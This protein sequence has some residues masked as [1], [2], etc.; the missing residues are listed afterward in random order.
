MDRA[1]G[2][3]LSEIAGAQ[4]GRRNF[5]QPG[6]DIRHVGECFFAGIGQPEMLDRAA[7]IPERGGDGMQAV[8]TLA[9]FTA[10]LAG[11]TALA[12]RGG[13]LGGV[14]RFRAAAVFV[15]VH[16]A[17]Y[18]WLAVRKQAA[19]GP[20][21]WPIKPILSFEVD[22]GQRNTIVRASRHPGWLPVGGVA[23]WLKAA[24]CKS[25]DISLRRF[26][27]YP[28]HHRHGGWSRLSRTA[29]GRTVLISFMRV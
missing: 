24:D 3:K 9:G 18:I 19:F 14:M 27:S 11:A 25:A 6:R 15:A 13:I 12:T 5:R 23:E 21:P 10:S 26:E 7:R 2:Q 20:T 22:N 16:P 8:N 4:P 28:L 29:Q 1:F 17:T